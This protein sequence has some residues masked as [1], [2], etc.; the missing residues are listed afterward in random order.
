MMVVVKECSLLGFLRKQLPDFC[1]SK[2]PPWS[3]EKSPVSK[4]WFNT[5]N[6]VVLIDDIQQ[7]E[8]TSAIN[9]N[10]FENLSKT[11]LET[12]HHFLLT[13]LNSA[14]SSKA[15][16]ISVTNVFLLP[17][18]VDSVNLHWLNKT[19]PKSSVHGVGHPLFFRG[20][21]YYD[22][23]TMST[24]TTQTSSWSSYFFP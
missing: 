23:T 20:W 13:K 14:F 24:R 18:T 5:F 19:F 22:S 1:V 15:F 16:F 3:S 7:F 12:W 17:F 2:P 21:D 8:K 6:S 11:L 10:I 9:E 4:I